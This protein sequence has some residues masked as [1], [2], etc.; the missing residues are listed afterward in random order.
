VSGTTYSFICATLLVKTFKS[1]QLCIA[2]VAAIV[3]Q[4]R[5]SVTIVV[6]VV[7]KL[8]LNRITDLQM[9]TRPLMPASL[10]PT[11]VEPRMKYMQMWM[12][13]LARAECVGSTWKKRI[14]PKIY[15]VTIAIT[16]N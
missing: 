4:A 5:Y 1:V 11:S 13:A 3:V 10:P 15:G 12:I 7:A 6:V 2:K 14:G 16:A 8:L 9:P